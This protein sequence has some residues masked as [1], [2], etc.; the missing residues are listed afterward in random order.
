MKKPPI[1][2]VLMPDGHADCP[3]CYRPKPTPRPYG[4]YC[5]SRPDKY[6][7]TEGHTLIL[8][9]RHVATL[10]EL[11]YGEVN[12]L[13]SMVTYHSRT[14]QYNDKTITGFNIGVNSGDSAGQTIKHLHVH[15]I[16]R[17]DGDVS[18]PR[19]GVRWVI[20]HKADYWSEPNA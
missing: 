15:I 6:P 4:Q 18:D 9:R 11:Y 1:T 13:W 19:G 16:P 14:M 7:V 17:R 5:Y 8:P 20:P 10:D 3:F 12:A 2:E